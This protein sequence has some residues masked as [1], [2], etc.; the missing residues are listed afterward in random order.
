MTPDLKKK[1]DQLEEKS[2][3]RYPPGAT[4]AT[5]PVHDYFAMMRDLR[6]LI[7]QKER[8]LELRKEER[9]RELEL[10]KEERKRKL[11]RRQARRDFRE[12]IGRVEALTEEANDSLRDMTEAILISFGYHRHQRSEWRLSCYSTV[13]MTF[14]DEVRRMNRMNQPNN[15]SDGASSKPDPT[16]PPLKVEAP[17]SGPPTPNPSPETSKSAPPFKGPPAPTPEE[18]QLFAA[19]RAGD[20]TAQERVRLLLLDRDRVDQLGDLGRQA[21]QR[22]IAA[23]TAGDPIRQSF[24]EEKAAAMWID[25]L[26]AK[27]SVLDRLLARRVINN[28]IVLHWL[29]EQL[30]AVPLDEAATWEDLDKAVSRA[31]RRYTESINALTQVRR[32]QAPKVLAETAFRRSRDVPPIPF[33]PE[34]PAGPETRADG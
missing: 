23:A 4:L 12:K 16:T 22:L 1:F 34:R 9:K 32:L 3:R 14:R 8:E 5:M 31:Q 30:A 19:A 18:A 17:K 2:R 28:F 27:P 29:E 6:L 7:L 20:A 24:L 33:H 21:T 25:L 11:L 13:L 15:P 26:G 10:H